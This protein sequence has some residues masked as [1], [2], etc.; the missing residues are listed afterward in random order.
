MPELTPWQIIAVSIGYLV[1]LFYFM[2]LSEKH[3][4]TERQESRGKSPTWVAFWLTI[5]PISIVLIGC[6]LAGLTIS[7]ALR[8]PSE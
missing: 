4:L 3:R 7:I 6:Y 8:P 5:W 1:G 2:H